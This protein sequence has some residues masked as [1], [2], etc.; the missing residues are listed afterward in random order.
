M[1]KRVITELIDDV[2]E[3]SS[4]DD[5][6]RFSL[7]GMHY[8]IDLTAERAEQLRATLRD[9]SSYARRVRRA[10]TSR[11]STPKPPPRVDREQKRAIREWA[12]RN[13]YTV[14]DRGRIPDRVLNAYHGH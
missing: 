9:W 10:P 2:D 5:T 11:P 14:S 13:G 8:E 12:R 1:V 6:V 4:A 3:E 7:D